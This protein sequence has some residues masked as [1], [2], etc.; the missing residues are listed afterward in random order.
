MKDNSNVAGNVLSLT[1]AHPQLGYVWILDLGCSNHI[2]SN[3]DW[4][5]TYDSVMVI[6][7]SWET[8]CYVRQLEWGQYKSKYTIAQ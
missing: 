3:R 7:S 4:F 2:C 1:F 5:T 6:L 8:T